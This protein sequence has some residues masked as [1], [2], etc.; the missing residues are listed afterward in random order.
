MGNR[1]RVL[2]AER[3]ITQMDLARKIGLAVSNY[4]RIEKG[5]RHPSQAQRQALARALRVSQAEIWPDEAAS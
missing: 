4:W 3:A 1:L 5:Y 2:R